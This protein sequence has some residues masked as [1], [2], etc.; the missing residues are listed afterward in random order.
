MDRVEMVEAPKCCSVH[1]ALKAAASRG[2]EATSH[3]YGFTLAERTPGSVSVAPQWHNGL[4]AQPDFICESSR[5]VS[6][7]EG[8]RRSSEP[9]NI[10]AGF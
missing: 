4:S 2:T 3:P 10:K 8:C 7:T 9:G 6:N 1:A 5:W